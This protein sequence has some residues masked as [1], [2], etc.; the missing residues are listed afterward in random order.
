MHYIVDI[1]ERYK[2]GFDFVA[3]AIAAN[4]QGLLNRG[5]FAAALSINEAQYKARKKGQTD[6]AYKLEIYSAPEYSFSDIELKYE[7]KIVK[8]GF[9]DIKG[10]MEGDSDIIAPPPLVRFKRTK[11][12]AVTVIDDG[13]EAE[14]VENF[15]MNSWDIEITGL[16]IDMK[17]HHYPQ[18]AM[19]EMASFFEINDIIEVTSM[20]FNDLGIHS[21]W[22]KEQT[23]D[24]VEGFPD[25]VKF[26]LTAKSIKPAEFSILNGD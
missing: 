6:Q 23:I 15:G 10:L 22:F 5:I 16:L 12:I 26:T 21:L 24:P 13:D 9:F 18:Q 11:N 1:L 3:G 2:G 19:K 4:A 7:K 17:N 8:F 20:L 14:I 25:T